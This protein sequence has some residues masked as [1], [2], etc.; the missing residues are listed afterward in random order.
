MVN[1][2][3]T[4]FAA[5]EVLIPNPNPNPNPD[6]GLDSGPVPKPDI[7]ENPEYY[8][9]DVPVTLVKPL[10]DDGT[11]HYK[12]TILWDQW[13]PQVKARAILDV[14]A[15]Q[16]LAL[17]NRIPLVV[18]TDPE[19][20]PALR[21]VGVI[22]TDNFLR[23]HLTRVYLMGVDDLPNSLGERLRD[24]QS[25]VDFVNINTQRVEIRSE[26][27]DIVYSADPYTGFVLPTFTKM[28]PETLPINRPA[29]KGVDTVMWSPYL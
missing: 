9:V 21:G 3:I 25:D 10:D 19:L 15:V 26:D 13:T 6:L 23:P 22:S 18:A 27:D 17:V 11:P 1:M 14:L 5:N 8:E 28:I 24:T 16:R 20:R 29:P 7:S 4:H 2:A 12:L